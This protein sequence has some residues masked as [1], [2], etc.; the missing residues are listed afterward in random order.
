M[1]SI[2]LITIKGYDSN[3]L[4]VRLLFS[5]VPVSYFWPPDYTQVSINWN[6][7]KI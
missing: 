1:E 3:N 2:T 7:I 5:S 6:G 4:L